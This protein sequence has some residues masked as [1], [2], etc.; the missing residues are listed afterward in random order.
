MSSG[1]VSSRFRT[2]VAAVGPIFS[3]V[4]GDNPYDNTFLL[5]VIIPTN[6][7]WWSKPSGLNGYTLAL[8]F[9]LINNDNN[10]PPRIVF[11]EGAWAQMFINGVL[12][13]FSKD[14]SQLVT[15]KM[16]NYDLEDSTQKRSNYHNFT[17]LMF[18]EPFKDIQGTEVFDSLRS[19]ALA[20]SSDGNGLV[21]GGGSDSPFINFSALVNNPY[22][23]DPVNMVPGVRTFQAGMNYKLDTPK[24]GVTQQVQI[25]QVSSVVT[26]SQ[27]TQFVDLPYGL[28]DSVM[29]DAAE[30]NFLFLPTR[31]FTGT[32]TTNIMMS[33]TL[34]PGYLHFCDRWGALKGKT[35]PFYESSC[36][37]T[38]E[39]SRGNVNQAQC[40]VVDNVMYYS[41]TLGN[42]CGSAW[43][44]GTSF[45]DLTDTTVSAAISLGPCADGICGFDVNENI[46]RCFE[47]TN[48][49]GET[50]ISECGNCNISGCDDCGTARCDN[51]Q[52]TV[53]QCDQECSDN[54]SCTS[55]QTNSRLPLWYYITTIILFVIFL[56]LFALIYDNNSKRK[57]VINEFGLDGR[58]ENP[59]INSET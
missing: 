39:N 16:N 41:A 52:P 10:I 24:S 9:C 14:V 5:A 22:S 53:T 23:V 8:G 45:V 7:T 26:A 20:W 32:C 58:N 57:T 49:S 17:N 11:A 59:L 47:A 54:M 12:P 29:V 2:D 21:L 19:L 31:W 51:F 44:S 34:L 56:I 6:A 42:N 48:S 33:P 27:S 1:V 28:G 35:T 25:F 13:P 30:L 4:F 50:C 46:F 36:S 43:R 3:T 15:F 55:C 18:F 40:G 37:G 38:I